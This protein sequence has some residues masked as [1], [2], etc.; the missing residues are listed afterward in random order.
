MFRVTT[1]GWQGPRPVV[2]IARASKGL[3]TL[4]TQYFVSGVD[5][6]VD[7]GYEAPWLKDWMAARQQTH[8]ID[9]KAVERTGKG[10]EAMK[11]GW[12]VEV[13]RL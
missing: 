1:G 12:K 7:D 13:S 4:W 3:K 2:P 9:L 5:A 10:F 6:W 8:K 11:Q